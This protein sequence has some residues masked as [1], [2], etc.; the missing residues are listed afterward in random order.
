MQVQGRSSIAIVIAV[1]LATA[2]CLG[3]LSG[4]TDVTASP[5]L[6]EDATASDGGYERASTTESTVNRTFSGGGE[7]RTVRVT[8]WAVEY[9]KTVGVG[10]LA[11]QKAAVFATF[12]SP[13][14]S[15]L[16][17]S[18]NP[19]SELGTTDLASRMQG[20]YQGLS[21]GDEVDR[22][23]VSVLESRTNVSTF[24]G[25]AE[26]DGQAVDVFVVVSEPVKHEGDYVL[27]MS[28]YPQQMDG[29]HQTVVELMRNLDH[30]ANA[31]ANDVRGVALGAET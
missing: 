29:E 11:D 13:E 10:V 27:T 21:V 22:V 8:N 2:G 1:S 17:Q 14:V 15:V 20:Q 7:E 5:A 6:V 31:T 9:H 26:F 4:T 23:Q 25:T 28:V 19:L 30:P 18:F 12:A 24:E 16:G 3:F